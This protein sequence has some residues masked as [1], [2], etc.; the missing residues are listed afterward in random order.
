MI[1]CN[2][3]SAWR[4]NSSCLSA[5][6]PFCSQSSWA[7]WR[8]WSCAGL[9][10]L[11]TAIACTSARETQTVPTGVGTVLGKPRF[12]RG[13][14]EPEPPD[15]PLKHPSFHRRTDQRK[16]ST[17]GWQFDRRSR[18]AGPGAGPDRSTHAARHKTPDRGAERPFDGPHH[19][20]AET[21]GLRN[22]R[23]LGHDDPLS[24]QA[25]TIVTVYR[26]PIRI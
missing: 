14:E 23:V 1:P 8:I 13:A 25:H 12:D 11:V 16:H 6:L 5:G 22:H 26:F 20:P 17:S 21:V 24:L 18:Q 10:I 4:Q 2:S 9:S 3:R 7:R 15:N 19:G